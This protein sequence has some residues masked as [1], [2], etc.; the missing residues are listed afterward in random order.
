M[1]SQAQKK[2]WVIAVEDSFEKI[3]QDWNW[4][5]SNLFLKVRDFIILLI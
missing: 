3:H 4:I 2:E 5:E 1:K